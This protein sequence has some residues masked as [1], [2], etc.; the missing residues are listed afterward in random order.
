M[1]VYSKDLIDEVA[2]LLN[3]EDFTYWS[4]GFHLASINSGQLQ[5][6][7]LKPDASITAKAYKLVAGVRQTLPDGSASFKD[8]QD[9]TLP[10]GTKLIRVVLNMGATGL[11]PG[12]APTI[13]DMD[14]VSATKPNWAADTA[15]AVVKHFMYDEKDPKVFWVSPPQ[16]SSAQ[17]YVLVNYNSIPVNVTS[18][19]GTAAISLPDEYYLTLLD[20]M[21]FKAYT[22]DT[23]EAYANRALYYRDAFFQG[24]GLQ[25]QIERTEDPNYKNTE[26]SASY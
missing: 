2:G 15:H 5:I 6:A 20:W 19:S 11:V 12:R 13:I 14:M 18:Y 1:A 9:A 21:M 24:L 17:G 4:S 16:P 22:K 8:P 7:L 10:A 25:A 23:D 26:A 3:D